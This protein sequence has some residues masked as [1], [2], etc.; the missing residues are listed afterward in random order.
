MD[1]STDGYWGFHW[2]DID[3]GFKNRFCLWFNIY[4]KKWLVP[5]RKVPLL[6]ILLKDDIGE[7]ALCIGLNLIRQMRCL[8]KNSFL[9]SILN[10]FLLNKINDKYYLY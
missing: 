4:S 6:G 7:V 5:Y 1:I 2:L 8:L 3:F 10:I 9:I